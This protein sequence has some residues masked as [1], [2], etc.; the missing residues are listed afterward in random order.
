MR[1]KAILGAILCAAPVLAACD[2]SDPVDIL[3]ATG[4]AAAA[5]VA[6]A[7]PVRQIT[8]SVVGSDAYGDVC[9]GGAGIWLISTGTGDI[10]HFGRAV[11]VSS[12]CLNLADFSTIGEMPFYLRAANG[13]EVHGLTT[14]IVYTDYGFDFNGV[15]TGGTGRFAGAAGELVFPTVPTGPGSWTSGVNGWIRY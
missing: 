7:G 2:A 5:S 14:S 9:G 1:S 11:M 15:V 12:I 4:E 6:S 3:N 13:D 10:S 8:G